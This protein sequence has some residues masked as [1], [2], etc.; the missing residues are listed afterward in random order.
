ML[1][2]LQLTEQ[3]PVQ[4]TWQIELLQ[5]T[6]PLAP[7][8]KSQ[9]ELALQSR[10]E[11]TPAVRAQLL[12]LQQ[13]APHDSPQVSAAQVAPVQLRWHQI[14]VESPQVFVQLV[15]EPQA[16]SEIP[17]AARMIF[18]HFLKVGTS[19]CNHNKPRPSPSERGFKPDIGTRVT[20]A[21]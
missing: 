4:V 5:L 21:R 12:P 10:L 8:V 13:R 19:A 2:S 16:I 9:V 7:T 14:W 18:I 17:R 1:A 11:L 6:L 20:W 15:D 3:E